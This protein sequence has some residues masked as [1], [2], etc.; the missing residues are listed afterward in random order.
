MAI[1]GFNDPKM[2]T[3]TKNRIAH[4]ILR[5]FFTADM[6]RQPFVTD[7]AFRTLKHNRN[8]VHYVKNDLLKAGIIVR[9]KH[10]YVLGGGSFERRDKI[11]EYLDFVRSGDPIRIQIG[12]YN[13][14][15][16]FGTAISP[17]AGKFEDFLGNSNLKELIQGHDVIEITR[18][19]EVWRL[20]NEVLNDYK[21]FD[22][23][24][25][26]LTDAILKAVRRANKNENKD[27]WNKQFDDRILGERLILNVKKAI[28][29]IL[30]S[31]I[32]A[33]TYSGMHSIYEK[34]VIK[35][36]LTIRELDMQNAALVS[37]IKELFS[38]PQKRTNFSRLDLSAAELDRAPEQDGIPDI[39]HTQGGYSN[40]FKVIYRILE[41]LENV[42]IRDLLEDWLTEKNTNLKFT[43]QIFYDFLIKDKLSKK[44]AWSNDD[45][46]I[47]DALDYNIQLKHS[48]DLV[49]GIL[50]I[51]EFLPQFTPQNDFYKGNLLIGIGKRQKLH[52]DPEMWQFV[53]QH[54]GVDYPHIIEL[55]K[56]CKFLL[57]KIQYLETEDERLAWEKITK[58]ALGDKSERLNRIPE[59]KMTNNTEEAKT[60]L[61]LT[62]VER[63][64]IEEETSNARFELENQLKKLIRKVKNGELIKGKC[65][66]CQ[67]H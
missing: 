36:V 39:W 19:D 41:N 53:L 14:R 2:K 60:T 52:A 44:A 64:E 34:I 40:L 16:I 25:P 50:A 17:E 48:Q 32:Y 65:D 10:V 13:L 8:E 42:P 30:C 5:T 66:L 56:R 23:Q 28:F 20:F 27:L 24:L 67:K 26:S 49:K 46:K 63:F 51:N 21:K 58:E 7:R 47:Y 9:R 22:W 35:L 31:E 61:S 45:Q 37:T 6:K 33:E 38:L 59:V 15:R 57:D 1:L 62:K 54:L 12:T 11:L 43:A 4:E 18:S 29:D 55:F 3:L